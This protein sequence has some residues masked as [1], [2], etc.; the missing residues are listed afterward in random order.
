MKVGDTVKLGGLKMTVLVLSDKAIRFEAHGWKCW[1]P[2]KALVPS[3]EGFHLADWFQTDE[4][5]ERFFN[6]IEFKEAA[7][8]AAEKTFHVEGADD[9]YVE[10]G[11]KVDGEWIDYRKIQNTAD[12]IIWLAGLFLQSNRCDSSADWNEI[13]RA[14]NRFA[15]EGFEIVK[16]KRWQLTY[17]PIKAA[18]A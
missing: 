13:L 12:E 10:A 1:F 8:E 9:G 3:G 6:H 2:K 18:A 4:Y 14:F 7:R 17:Q 11:W 16:G 5:C 15:P